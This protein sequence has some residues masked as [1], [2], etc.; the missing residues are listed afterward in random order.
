VKLACSKQLNKIWVDSYSSCLMEIIN[1]I[2]NIITSSFKK[3]NCIALDSFPVM[4]QKNIYI[5]IFFLK[6]V[7]ALG[8]SNY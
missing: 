3:K 8:K 2:F 7:Y 6:I 5:Y 1:A 4:L